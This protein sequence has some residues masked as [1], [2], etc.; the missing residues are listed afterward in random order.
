ML[1]KQGVSSIV[2]P[3]LTLFIEDSV[4]KDELKAKLN[5][6]LEKVESELKRSEAMLNNEKFINKAPK[7]KVDLEKAKYEQY[8]TQYSEI[9]KKLENL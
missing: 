7:Q 2:L 1:D 8:K 9:K 6:D 3:D 5:K 4:N